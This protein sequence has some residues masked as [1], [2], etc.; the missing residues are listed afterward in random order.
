MTRFGRLLRKHT[1]EHLRSYLMGA[2][3]LAGGI[4]VVLGGLTYIG[5][6]PLSPVVQLTMFYFGLLAAGTMFT[7]GVFAALGDPRRAAPALLLPTSHLEKYLVVWLYSLPVF[8]LVYVPVFLAVDALTLQLAPAGSSRV[9]FDFA[10][11]P[12]ELGRALLS[13][14]LLHAATLGCALYFERLHIVKTA[15]VLLGGV[16]ALALLNFQVLKRVLTPDIAPALPFDDVGVGVGKQY[17]NL[18]LPGGQGELLA[19]LALA[20]AGLLWLGA[21]ARLTEKQL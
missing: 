15:F 11:A 16:G 13:Y 6:R 7:A 4:A 21:Y 1:A 14:A 8:L 19:L 17:F 12:R 20:L 9:M 5:G 18:V 10:A 3:V 2:A